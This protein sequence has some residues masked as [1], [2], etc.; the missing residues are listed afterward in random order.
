MAGIVAT[1]QVEIDAPVERVWEALTEPARI[2]KYMFGTHV[3]TD[4]RVGSPITWSGQYQGRL[5]EDKGEIVE[6]A[7]PRRLVVTHYS[8]LSGA[9]DVPESYHRLSYDLAGDGPTEVRLSQDNNSSPEEAEHSR[10][11]WETML[12]G[13]KQHVEAG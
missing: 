4:W 1:A 5:Y 7:A 9:P 11:N 2:E 12:A 6:C 8:P 3:E 13:L 10:A